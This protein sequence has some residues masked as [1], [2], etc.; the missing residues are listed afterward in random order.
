[1]YGNEDGSIPAT[2]QIL[3]MIGWKPS[4]NQVCVCPFLPTGS[5]K[6]E[7]SPPERK[8]VSSSHSRVIPK[9]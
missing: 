5:V 4:D 1:M 9:T 2:Y 8:V 6:V 7:C 3:Y